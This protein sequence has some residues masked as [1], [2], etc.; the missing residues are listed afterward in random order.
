LRLGSGQY[1]REGALSA[2]RVESRLAAI[3]ASDNATISHDLIA[4]TARANPAASGSV[5]G[6]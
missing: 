1:L 6:W 2:R 3:L 4:G 5:I